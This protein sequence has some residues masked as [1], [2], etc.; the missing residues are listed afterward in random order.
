M[1]TLQDFLTE[2]SDLIIDKQF[3]IDTPPGASDIRLSGTLISANKNHDIIFGHFGHRFYISSSDIVSI[4][5]LKD[6]TNIFEEG[7]AVVIT[8]KANTQLIPYEAVT[9]LNFYS[10]IPFAV[11]RPSQ[12]PE[13]D[14]PRFTAKELAWLASAGIS[15]DADPGTTKLNLALQ[16]T[17]SFR[18]IH[19]QKVQYD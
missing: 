2:H 5:E 18:T 8:V 1:A 12:I 14:Y 11:A 19:G 6:I 16:V 3:P 7:I 10:G 9:A 15:I 13:I 4:D 17:G